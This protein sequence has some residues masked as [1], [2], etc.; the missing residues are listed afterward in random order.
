MYVRIL[1]VLG[2]YGNTC[3]MIYCRFGNLVS[4]FYNGYL[5]F[6]VSS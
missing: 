5:A 2:E 1:E 3:R 4:S 6:Y